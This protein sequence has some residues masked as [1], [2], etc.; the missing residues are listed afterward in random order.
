MVLLN[1]LG[2]A[3][4]AVASQPEGERRIELTVS[5][6]GAEVL[7][8]IEDSGPG[9]APEVRSRIFDPFVT[10][11]PDGMGLGLAISRS[12]LRSQGGDVWAENSRLGGACF[13]I[14]M[15]M[16]TMAQVAL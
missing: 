11:K 12:L 13:I 7:L 3:I 14:R 2:N 1:L 10:T 15:P 8:S 6:R 16:A 9:L 4:D 5:C